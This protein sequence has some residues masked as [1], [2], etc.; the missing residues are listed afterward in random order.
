MLKA[1]RKKDMTNGIAAQREL[2]VSRF[3]PYTRHVNDTT[4][5]TKEGYLLKII[6]IAGIPFETADQIDINQRKNIRA[7]LLRGL[8]N[9]RFAIYHNIIRREASDSL[10]SFF[11]NSWC[12][13]LDKAYQEKLSKKKMYINEQY[14][15]IVR[16]PAQG[17]VGL[18]AEIGK[19]LFTKIDRKFQEQQ[20]DDAQKALDDAVSNIL[21]TLAPYKGSVAR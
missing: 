20:E 18:A 4:L 10:D 17:A 6:K 12:Q 5:K 9:S 11:E 7:T 8:S 14:I 21:T 2:S 19:M 16:R 3:I 13:N 15:T 1:A